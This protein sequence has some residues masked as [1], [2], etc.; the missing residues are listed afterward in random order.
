M[1]AIHGTYI[2]LSMPAPEEAF[3]NRG[4]SIILLKEIRLHPPLLKTL[5]FLN[6]SKTR[7][8]TKLSGPHESALLPR[9]TWQF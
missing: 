9:P 8:L 7:D 6:Q 3:P 4:A 1:C 5:Q 2:H